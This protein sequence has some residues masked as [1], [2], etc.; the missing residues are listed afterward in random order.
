MTAY[1]T[2]ASVALHN[3]ITLIIQINEN[4]NLRE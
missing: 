3:H 4:E 1:I 2:L